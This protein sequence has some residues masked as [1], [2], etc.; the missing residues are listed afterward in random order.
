MFPLKNKPSAKGVHRERDG[1]C[2]H[3]GEVRSYKICYIT[4]ENTHFNFSPYASD[5]R[6]VKFELFAV[7]SGSC[8]IRRV[9]IVV[10]LGIFVFFYKSFQP[11]RNYRVSG[12]QI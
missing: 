11:N 4:L 7:M 6:I 2:P 3:C 5:R 12:N 9:E 1:I 10:E 8:Q